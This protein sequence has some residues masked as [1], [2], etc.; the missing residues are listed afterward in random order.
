MKQKTYKANTIIIGGGIAGITTAIELLNANKTVII[1]ERDFEK[2]F[3]G[4]AKESFGGMFF[5]NSRQQRLSKIKD[6]V[7]QAKKDWFSFAEFDENEVWGKKW[8]NEFLES[9]HKIYEWVSS[10]KVKFFPVVHWVE[11]GLLQPGNSA[12]RFHMVWGT[13]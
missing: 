7:E 11:R 3:G 4:L 10:K 8:A 1:I 13:I 6:T 9:T 12:P 5:I 2:N